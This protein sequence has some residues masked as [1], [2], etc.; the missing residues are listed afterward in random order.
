MLAA[1]DSDQGRLRGTEALCQQPEIKACLEHEALRR[2]F[3]DL[4]GRRAVTYDF[5]WLRAVRRG[6]SSGFHMDTVYMGNCA[7]PN[8]LTCWIPLMAVPLELGG[9]TVCRGSCSLP[10]FA[11]VR[12]SY[13]RLDLDSGDVGGTG[14]FSEDPE[15]VAHFGG[16]WQTADFAPGDV[17]VFNMHTMH[18]SSVNQ[19][20]RWRLSF[21]VRWQP[22]DEPLDSRWM[23]RSADGVIPGDTSRWALH[24]DDPVEFPRTMNMAKRDWGLM[25]SRRALVAEAKDDS[26]P[27]EE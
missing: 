14:W 2:F 27:C 16:Q 7:A 5:K 22:E 20:S 24:R 23:R 3:G 11:P 21:D 19:T 12:E 8:L 10:T 4:F 9:L 6:Q 1:G 26:L 17:V 25:G 18:G 13:G 15:E